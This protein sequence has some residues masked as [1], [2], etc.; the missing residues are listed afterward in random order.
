MKI[1]K[2]VGI[3]AAFVGGAIVVAFAL[4]TF[5]IMVIKNPFPQKAYISFNKSGDQ[6]EIYNESGNRGVC[7]SPIEPGCIGVSKWRRANIKFRLVNMD[8]WSFKQIQLVA[9]P[10]TKLNFGTQTPPLSTE[11]KADFY[12]KVNNIDTQPDDNGIIDLTGLQKGY[13][14]KLVDRNDFKQI[15]SY[16]IEAC[17]EDEC[18]KLD[19]KIENEGKK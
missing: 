2:V 11:M 17:K 8:G 9:A 13:K 15:Y 12:V 10:L 1:V 6:L 18:I 3:T 14:F 7:A 4:G 19:P 5:G 16:Q